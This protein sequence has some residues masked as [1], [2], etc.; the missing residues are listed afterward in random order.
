MFLYTTQLRTTHILG[1]TQKHPLPIS[2]PTPRVHNTPA[3]HARMLM[4]LVTVNTSP[5]S[6]TERPKVKREEVEERMVLLV[7]LVAERLRLKVSCAAN[8]RGAT[9]SVGND[10]GG[11]E[12]VMCE[13]KRGV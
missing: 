3:M 6:S 9:C 5:S 13:K 2:P 8:H 4:S 1:N 12:K 10:G 7:T 11:E